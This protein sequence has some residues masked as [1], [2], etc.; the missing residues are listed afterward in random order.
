MN[1]ERCWYPRGVSMF[2][3]PQYL[4]VLLQPKK[5]LT[6]WL[7]NQ[8][9]SY[10]GLYS[11]STLDFLSLVAFHFSVPQVSQICLSSLQVPAQAW[12][13]EVVTVSEME[14]DCIN[15]TA[16]KGHVYRMTVLQTQNTWNQNNW[17][18]PVI[19]H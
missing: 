6:L 9:I 17:Q 3:F 1:T 19:W 2:I 18:H 16:D 8:I 7:R 5:V 15:V 13:S 12:L 10:R 11:T 4:V 14:H